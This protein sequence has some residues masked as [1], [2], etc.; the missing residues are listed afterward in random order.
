MS[1]TVERVRDFVQVR[2]RDHGPGIPEDSEKRIFD[3]FYRGK[4]DRQV[5]GS[6][7]GLALVRHIAIAHGGRA[8]ASNADDG[9]A[10]VA[11]AIP[12]AQTEV[13]AAKPPVA[14]VR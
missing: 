12:V 9:G 13:A 5:R 14:A 1:V 10:V 2:V 6:G 8:W 7:I 11:F 4:R 3:R